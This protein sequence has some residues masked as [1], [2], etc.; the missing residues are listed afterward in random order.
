MMMDGT[1]IIYFRASMVMLL[2]RA[3]NK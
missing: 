3:I 1:V 2:V